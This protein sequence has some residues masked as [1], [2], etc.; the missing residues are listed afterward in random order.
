[1]GSFSKFVAAVARH[2]VNFIA[3]VSKDIQTLNE[4][5][6]TKPQPM[7]DEEMEEFRLFQQ[8]KARSAGRMAK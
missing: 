8:A 5:E 1:M 2:P 6:A 7:T 3:D 4:Q